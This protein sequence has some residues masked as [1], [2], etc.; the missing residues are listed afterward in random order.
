VTLL[1]LREFVSKLEGNSV[2]VTNMSFAGLWRLCK[3]F[4]LDEFAARLSK[5]RHLQGFNRAEARGRIAALE[6]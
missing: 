6:K 1:I 4:G 3:K 5:L 2:T